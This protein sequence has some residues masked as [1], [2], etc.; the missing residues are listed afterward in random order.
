VRLGWNWCILGWQ[1]SNPSAPIPG[2]I[3]TPGIAGVTLEQL[4]QEGVTIE[5][6]RESE[7][8]LW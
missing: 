1:G 8:E 3:Y 7:L 5:Q 4:V 6:L 2:W